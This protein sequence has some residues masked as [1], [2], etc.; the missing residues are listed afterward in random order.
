MS[1]RTDGDGSAEGSFRVPSARK[2]VH[3]VRAAAPGGTAAT[4][5][6]RVT[7]RLRV[8][9]SGAGAGATVR[10]SLTGFAPGEPVNVQWPRPDG[11]YATVPVTLS[12]GTRTSTPVVDSRGSGS[13]TVTVPGDAAPGPTTLRAIATTGDSRAQVAFSVAGCTLSPTTGQAGTAVAVSCAGFYLGETVDLFWE[14]AGTPV[15]ASFVA[16]SSGTGSATFK[17]PAAVG[18][19]HA[20]VATGRTSVR[21]ATASVT[22]RPYLRLTPASGPAGA[23]VDARLYGFRPGERVCVAWHVTP[24]TTTTPTCDLVA[25]ASGSTPSFTVTVPTDASTGAHRVAAQ[26]SLGTAA[27]RTFNVT[28]GGTSIS[29]P[30]ATT[31]PTPATTEMPSATS[32]GVPTDTPTPTETTTAVPTATPLPTE[33]PTA[34]PTESPTPSPTDTP[35]PTETPTPVP[36][37]TPSPTATPTV[38]RSPDEEAAGP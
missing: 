17:L 21:T 8:S 14:R 27:E 16:T 10:V 23:S 3:T 1:V 38:T 7:P 15:R 20:V 4:A 33:S 37:E 26:G 18:G 12:D 5:R 30:T 24:D 19:A 13:Y 34:V 32:T 31:T 35:V 29:D 25:D 28:V 11:A 36:T 2:G 22:V 6:F 9:P